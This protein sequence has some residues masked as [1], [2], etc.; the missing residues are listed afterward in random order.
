MSILMLSLGLCSLDETTTV[1]LPLDLQ[2]H[3]LEVGGPFYF[4]VLVNHGSPSA[5]VVL[6][7]SQEI[8]TLHAKLSEAAE[9]RLSPVPQGNVDYMADDERKA[10]YL[11]LSEWL[12]HTVSLTRGAHSDAVKL[13]VDFLDPASGAIARDS[14]ITMPP[15]NS[16]MCAFRHFF[17]IQVG[18]H[19][20][21]KA[22]KVFRSFAD[23]S[24]LR[25]ELGD[26]ASALSDI[27]FPTE[28]IALEER[29]RG[30]EAWLQTVMK[31]RRDEKVLEGPL[32]KFLD[33]KLAEE[34]Y[35]SCISWYVRL[36][37]VF[38][39]PSKLPLTALV[40]MR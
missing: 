28:S 15:D 7:T 40:K 32:Q 16:K 33:P 1:S 38:P 8:Q 9:Y 35:E 39:T 19:I 17:G 11:A 31:R 4:R 3:H 26:T 22:A 6:R 37:H 34:K 30:L 20:G 24:K 36:F 27:R 13:M 10:H 21:S 25:E 12:Q 18:D 29:R 2:E 5:W 14:G 23:F